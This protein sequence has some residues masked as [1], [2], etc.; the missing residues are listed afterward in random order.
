[1]W[2]SIKW[3]GEKGYKQLCFG[4]TEPGNEG[5]RQFKNGWGTEENTINYYR[6]DLARDAFISNTPNAAS[7]V[8]KLFTKLPIPI[9]KGIGNILYKHVG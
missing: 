8:G 5:L 4:R 7:R 1:M 9:L 3:Y 6:Y 2:E